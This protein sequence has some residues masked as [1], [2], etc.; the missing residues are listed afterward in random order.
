MGAEHRRQEDVA[1]GVLGIVITHGDLL[2]HHVALDLDIVCGATPTQHHVCNQVDSQFEIGVEHVRVIAGVFA[3]GERVEFT[4]DRVDSLRDLDRGARRRGLE[5]QV[6]QEVR[7]TG[8]AG[9]LVTGAHVDPHPHRCGMHRRDVL[10][11]HTQA[12]GQHGATHLGKIPS[13]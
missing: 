11:D 2:E 13:R 4:T 12:T 9:P 7:R 3:G 8:N 1:E 5:Q 6:F 10:G